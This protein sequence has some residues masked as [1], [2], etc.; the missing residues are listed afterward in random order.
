V[1]IDGNDSENKATNASSQNFVAR[2]IE[3]IS[4]RRCGRLDKILQATSK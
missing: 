3:I 2:K 1:E 4:V